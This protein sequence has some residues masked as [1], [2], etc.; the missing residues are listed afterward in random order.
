MAS[1]ELSR[2]PTTAGNRKTWTFSAWFKRSKVSSGY[3][4]LFS[5]YQSN[6]DRFEIYIHQNDTITVESV[7]GTNQTLNL[8][9]NRKFRDTSAWYHIVV[10]IDTTQATS[11]DRVK[12][13][14]NGV[15]ETSFS[16]STYMSQN[17]NTS[18]NDT[19]IQYIG[20]TGYNSGGQNFDGLMAHVHLVDGTAHDADTFGSTDSTTG[21]WKPKTSPSV[22]YGTN[23]FFLDFA[24]SS[25]MGND[26]SGNNNDLTVSGT[27]T[28][29]I[30]TP[31]NVFATL[32][33]LESVSTFSNGNTKVV[34]NT[35]GYWCGASTLG[36]TSGKYY[37]E[38]KYVAESAANQA[39][40]SVQSTENVRECFRQNYHSNQVSSGQNVLLEYNG[41]VYKD[42]G[43]A[44]TG[45]WASVSTGDIVM[46]ALD[47]DNQY[48]YFGK[49]GTWGNSSDPTSGS[50][51]TGGVSLSSNTEEWFF[52]CG[53]RGTSNTATYAWNFGNGYFESTAVSSAGTNSGIGTFEYDVPSGYKALCTKNI[54]A[55][56]YS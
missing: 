12:L 20:E 50:S 17:E 4:R 45:T 39:N 28:Q 10:A 7:Y 52:G 30:D 14:I 32:N 48:V 3:P 13:Y 49:N 46:I 56:E 8:V 24:D 1:V 21:I 37:A 40:I 2:T 35:S 44:V 53:D 41:S 31:S 29:T 42:Q 18:T 11:S 55:E 23:G 22:T 51:G 47:L 43:S 15:Q 54:N 34:G 33:P 27:L 25:A 6:N 16:S 19:Y 5:S 9:T 36:V 38:V 26:V